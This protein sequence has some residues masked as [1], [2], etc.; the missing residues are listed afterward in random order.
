[1]KE[2]ETIIRVEIIKDLIP[3]FLI[4]KMELLKLIHILQY[5]TI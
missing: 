3:Y 1:M 5:L 2:K 4:L